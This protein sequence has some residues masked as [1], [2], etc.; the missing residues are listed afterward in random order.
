MKILSA[1][2]GAVKTSSVTTDA[3][4][5]SPAKTGAV[6]TAS[7]KTDAVKT[8][9]AKTGA[10][11]TS[12]VATDAV[13][14]SPAKTD[15]VKT[16]SVKR[17]LMTSTHP[18]VEA[19]VGKLMI[20][21]LE[22]TFLEDDKNIKTATSQKLSD[23]KEWKKTAAAE[24]KCFYLMFDGRVWD[25]YKQDEYD[26]LAVK[27][28]F[29]LFGPPAIENQKEITNLLDAYTDD[30]AKTAIRLKDKIIKSPACKLPSKVGRVLDKIASGL[31]L[32]AAGFTIVGL[33]TP[34]AP[35]ILTTATVVGISSATYGTVRSTQKL[36]DKGTHGESL[37]D[38]ESLT[39][40]TAIASAVFNVAT[41]LTN[42]VV[43]NMAKM[44]NV[45][46][47][48]A[49][50]GVTILNISTF[51]ID[52]LSIALAATNLTVKAIN[53][54]LTALDVVQ[55]CV[56]VFFFT[57][58]LIQPKTAGQIIKRA[59]KEHLASV[60]QNIQDPAAQ[61]EFDNFIAS[62]RGPRQM[63][64]NADLIKSIRYI[65][66]PDEFFTS[67]A[68]TGSI[69]I[70]TKEGTFNING[71]IDIHPRAFHEIGGITNPTRRVEL[72]QATA[73]YSRRRI[74]PEQYRQ[75]IRS[76][77]REERLHFLMTQDEIKTKVAQA[78]N[79]QDLAQVEIGN[80]KIFEN[81]S[82]AEINRLGGTLSA[83]NYKQDVIQAAKTIANE[84]KYQT[85][86][87][88]CSCVEL[89]R[90]E[91]QMTDS[92]LMSKNNFFRALVKL[93]QILPSASDSDL[94]RI[95]GNF[96]RSV[97]EFCRHQGPQNLSDTEKQMIVSQ[98]SDALPTLESGLPA[99]FLPLDADQRQTGKI[100]RSAIQF[101][102]DDFSHLTKDI[103][104]TTMNSESEQ[105]SLST[106]LAEL[107]NCGP[108]ESLHDN[109]VYW[110]NDTALG[111][112]PCNA[113]AADITG[114]PNTH[115]WWT[116]DD[117]N[118]KT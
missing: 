109:L 92:L 11:K 32:A 89:V 24:Q 36:V 90:S 103:E 53:N 100:Y 33:F 77:Q 95:T 108:V 84:R 114:V 17:G 74:T 110:E 86:E 45:L 62:N 51:S 102:I 19:D 68:D 12:S 48:S 104:T 111:E 21:D 85:V 30:Q 80:K 93:N 18:S 69:V 88:F 3:M 15:A 87:D 16:T 65:K 118:S 115:I 37:T 82:P 117:R 28:A 79:V 5:T 57:N 34:L 66:N 78:F 26:H 75:K 47:P 60:R 14:T 31:G 43:S 101:L 49:R 13:K 6:K 8:T 99:A 27:V 4:T 107:M 2:T 38:L 58:T 76:Y 50:V 44:G 72:L 1:T 81:M 40:W 116:N 23:F 64:G 59:Q 94:F 113:P 39:A 41:P 96:L 98:L 9:P 22:I 71:Q 52:F 35:V 97:F 20:K 7:A 67:V 29:A 55:F 42:G 46:Q 112:F 105:N 54:Q 70:L 106:R 83:D 61:K 10:V 56:S 73:D 63:H 91:L 25:S